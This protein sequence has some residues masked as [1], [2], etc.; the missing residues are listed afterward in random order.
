MVVVVD[1]CIPPVPPSFLPL[2]H[3][4]NEPINQ[5]NHQHQPPTQGYHAL[6]DHL[7]MGQVVS[8]TIAPSLARM[9][10]KCHAQSYH[11]TSDEGTFVRVYAYVC[12]YMF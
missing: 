11:P 2:P 5:N 3:Q 7:R 10:A 8:R 1:T 6:S 9:L 4:T 12:V